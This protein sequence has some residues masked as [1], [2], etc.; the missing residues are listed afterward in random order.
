MDYLKWELERQRR[1]LRALLPGGGEGR[2]G[3][4]AQAGKRPYPAEPETAWER[5]AGRAGQSAGGHGTAGFGA[6]EGWEAVRRASRDRLPRESVSPE[7]AE[8]AWERVLSAEAG[9]S[10]WEPAGA[11][12][13]AA[14]REESAAR[15][16]GPAG[17]REP[18]APWAE[19]MGRA[20]TLAGKA[21]AGESS[22]PSSGGGETAGISAFAARQPES[23]TAWAPDR[24]GPWARSASA[25]LQAEDGARALSRAVQRDARR[26]D[27]GFHIY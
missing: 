27:G 26:Y 25:A 4:S 19:G 24:S 22:A 10:G 12:P 7:A 13:W 23:G 18:A 1:A 5:A 21:R 9:D 3:E 16:E 11:A 17:L 20:D 2:D 15:A 8:S 14:A 6:G